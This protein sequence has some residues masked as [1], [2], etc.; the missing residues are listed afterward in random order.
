MAS[1]KPNVII[2]ADGNSEIGYG[3]LFRCLALAQMLNQ[4]FECWFYSQNPPPFLKQEIEKNAHG[5]ITLTFE[6]NPEKEARELTQQELKGDEI[7]VLDGYHF[8][9]PYQNAIKAN[10]NFLVV[11]DDMAE[12][13]FV[14]D[15]VI[16]H[17]DGVKEENYSTE[18][19][20]RLCLGGKYALLR[21][22]FLNQAREDRVF[23]QIQSIF[24]SLGGSNQQKLLGEVMEACEDLEV[25]RI[26]V[27][28]NIKKEQKGYLKNHK[29]PV[30]NFYEHLKAAE[31]CNLIKSCQIALTPSSTLSLECC[32]V[33][34]GLLTGYTIK[35]QHFIYE[36]LV[37]KEM[38][39]PLGDLN[40][41]EKSGLTN[42]LKEFINSP[43]KVSSLIAN[44]R[45]VFDGYSDQRIQNVFAELAKS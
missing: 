17:A 25:S 5:L 38:T 29:Q 37:K 18:Y 1:N 36:G 4:D 16:N 19:Y 8:D 28:G 22:P 11:I 27:L 26:N 21:P 24:I 10:G 13:H 34:V 15:F 35:N 14:A 9:L 42:T 2:R 30:F 31:V 40:N 32:A 44:Q 12:E 7:V 20:T 41:L 43:Q 23:D 33:G 39:E 6:T 3:H 45:A